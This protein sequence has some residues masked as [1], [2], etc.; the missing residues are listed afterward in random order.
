MEND[1][2]GRE[3]LEEIRRLRADLR[4]YARVAAGLFLASCAAGLVLFYPH[5]ILKDQDWLGGALLGILLLGGFLFLVG[6]VL[7]SF[8]NAL[9][10][11]KREQRELAILSGRT[12]GARPRR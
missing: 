3:C 8:F 12:A 7:Q 6:M 2:A 9:L 11:R 4:R 1:D 5:T 10:R